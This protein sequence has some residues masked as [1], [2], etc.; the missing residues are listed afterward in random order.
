MHGGAVR[1]IIGEAMDEDEALD[2]EACSDSEEMVTYCDG[3]LPDGDGGPSSFRWTS[4]KERQGPAPGVDSS[5]VS[6][7][8]TVVSSGSSAS[9]ITDKRFEGFDAGTDRSVA[10]G[11][12]GCGWTTGIEIGSWSSSCLAS[13]SA[14]AV[15][16]PTV[17]L[18]RFRLGNEPL[19]SVGT[20]MGYQDSS[21]RPGWL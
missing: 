20:P 12:V 10:G 6:S 21:S 16:T 1:V 11:G 15:I 7:S 5:S 18:R 3:P 14:R 4:G 19:R 13:A 9:R 2:E 17:D 8:S